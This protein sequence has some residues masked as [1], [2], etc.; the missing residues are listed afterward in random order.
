MLLKM[1]TPSGVLGN[2]LPRTLSSP[3]DILRRRRAQLSAEKVLKDSESAILDGLTQLDQDLLLQVA[4][5][6]IAVQVRTVNFRKAGMDNLV[7]LWHW[8]DRTIYLDYHLP[9]DKFMGTL[10]HEL[11]HVL[12]YRADGQDLHGAHWR[13]MNRKLGGAADGAAKAERARLTPDM[14]MHLFIYV[15]GKDIIVRS[16]RKRRKVRIR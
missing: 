11:A 16:D 3:F 4:A 10:L 14:A 15:L 13:S 9:A 12:T 6:G 5:E 8:D 1:N 7:G 2:V